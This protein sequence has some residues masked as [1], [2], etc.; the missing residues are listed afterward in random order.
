MSFARVYRST[1]TSPGSWRGE[2]P[3]DQDGHR[4]PTRVAAVGADAEGPRFHL[5]PGRG[6]TS[7]NGTA[8]FTELGKIDLV[9]TGP[10][11]A[12]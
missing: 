7:R 6:P 11:D 3:I 1:S 8:S 2:Y 5:K 12:R 4:G 10:T 9:R